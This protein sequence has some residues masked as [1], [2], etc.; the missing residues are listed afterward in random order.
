MM[1][2]RKIKAKE[3]MLTPEPRGQKHLKWTASEHLKLLKKS[4]LF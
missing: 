2:Q 4:T 3:Q 1:L